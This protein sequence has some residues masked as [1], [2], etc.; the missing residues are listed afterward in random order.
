MRLFRTVA[1][2]TI[3]FSNEDAYV[4]FLVLI[5]S[6]VATK[7]PNSTGLDTGYISFRK[8]TSITFSVANPRDAIFARVF[9]RIHNKIHKTDLRK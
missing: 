2:L 4:T 7:S 5:S 8:P 1:E 9:S 3:P 6:S